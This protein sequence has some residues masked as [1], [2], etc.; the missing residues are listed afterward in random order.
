MSQKQKLT[1]QDLK[2]IGLSSLG[3]TLEFYDFIIVFFLVDVIS[4]L[5]FPP[6]LSPF[7]ATLNTYGTFAAS[8]LARPLG[9]II[10]AHFGDKFGRKNMFMLS[11]LLMVIPTFALAFIPT[12]ESI[13]YA[14][15]IFLLLVRVCQ[16]IAIGGELPGAWVFVYEHA[17]SKHRNTYI[18]FLTASVVGGIFCGSIVALCLNLYFPPEV[19]KEWAWRLPFALGGVFGI[20]S[21]YLRKFLHE[22]PVFKRMSEEK[23]IENFPLKE[24]LKNARSSVI[25]SMLIT[26]VLTGCIL[27]FILLMPT[28]F[29]GDVMGISKVN[30]TYI[31]IV[32]ISLISFACALTGVLSDKFS[33]YKVCVIF[34][35]LFMIC[36]FLFFRELYFVPSHDLTW[37]LV[38]YF[39]TCFFGGIMNFCPIFMNMLFND[40]IR[41][42]GVSFSYNIAYAIAGYITPPLAFVLHSAAKSLSASSSSLASGSGAV[43]SGASSAI[44]SSFL[45]TH[46]LSLYMLFLGIL[47]LYVCY[48]MSK[49][50]I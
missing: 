11:I 27:V 20:I 43:P 47:S 15:P 34:T 12:F 42:S 49:R 33:A 1:K 5:F 38:F 10:M 28:K 36:S 39:L 40:R 14:A 21:I 30:M 48:A 7:W 13:G 35:L 16:G 8:Y 31:Q 32:G 17:D 3:G 46:G 25:L 4:S 41:F 26:F 44:E 24:V 9:G 2:I 29:I 18:G 23:Q 37:L 6:H 45:L 50:G 19:I 22:T